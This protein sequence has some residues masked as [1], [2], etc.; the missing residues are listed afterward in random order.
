MW[1]S[2]D[3]TNPINYAYSAIVRY[4]FSLFRL[5]LVNCPDWNRKFYFECLMKR[6]ATFTMAAT[7]PLCSSEGMTYLGEAQ[8]TN[9]AKR[10]AISIII[11]C[12]DMDELSARM[13]F[14]SHA[15]RLSKCHSDVSAL[16]SLCTHRLRTH[17]RYRPFNWTLL[18]KHDFKIL[19]EMATWGAHELENDNA[20]HFQSHTGRIPNQFIGWDASLYDV[21]YVY[22]IEWING[23]Y[24]R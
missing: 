12:R 20:T 5:W 6:C 19:P 14:G 3:A 22:A 18:C 15:R 8:R 16:V 2:G 21:A 4:F 17:W 13:A 24:F 23:D 10:K 1:S 7:S 11:I 9:G